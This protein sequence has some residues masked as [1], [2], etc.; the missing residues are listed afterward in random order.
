MMDQCIDQVSSQSV[1]QLIHRFG[2]AI[3]WTP[4]DQIASPP[5]GPLGGNGSAAANH[6]ASTANSACADGTC[7]AAGVSRDV[8]ASSQ[9]DVWL[10]GWP[11]RFVPQLTNNKIRA[12]ANQQ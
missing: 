3:H 10:A 11:M 5:A 1:A 4:P 8:P 7:A 9:V 6:V 12:E 2:Q